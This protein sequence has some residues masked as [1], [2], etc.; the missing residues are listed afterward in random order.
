MA[1]PQAPRN[2]SFLVTRRRFFEATRTPDPAQVNLL[3]RFSTVLDISEAPTLDPFP[4]LARYDIGGTRRMDQD[5]WI[6][7]AKLF[8]FVID[9]PWNGWQ[10]GKERTHA[11]VAQEIHARSTVNTELFSYILVE[12]VHKSLA[13]PGEANHA[14]YLTLNT[15]KLWA[16]Q[17]GLTEAGQVDY[18]A[19]YFQNNHATT[20]KLVGGKRS[21]QIVAD[22]YLSWLVEGATV[23]N[24]VTPLANAANP[25]LDGIFID[26]VFP[27]FK[28]GVGNISADMDRNGVADN[29]SSTASRQLAQNSQVAL[30]DYIRTRLP[31]KKLLGNI[32]EWYLAPDISILSG[33]LNGGVIEGGIGQSYS[34]ETF[35]S[36]QSFINMINTTMAALAEPKW[37]VVV[38]ILD[39]LTNYSL[40][41]Y[42]LAA[43]SMT[44]AY[45]HTSLSGLQTENLTIY[46][47]YLVSLGQPVAGPDGAVQTAPRY[48]VGTNGQPVLIWRR[49]F[50]HGIVLAAARRGT[51]AL[52]SSDQT[53]SYASIS[54][55]GTFYR[56]SG[57]QDAV[58]N[59]GA[60]VQNIAMVPRTGLVLLRTT[61]DDI[62]P[63]QP[64]IPVLTVVS[65]TRI[66]ISWTA[67]TDSGGSGLG[68]Y[69]L[70][71]APESSPGS[72]LP[73][74]WAQISVQPGT[75][76]S[77]ATLSASTKY[78]YRVVAFDNATPPNVGI[79]S[80]VANA[81]TQ[82]SGGA[83]L[84]D[85]NFSSGA[86]DLVQNGVR[87]EGAGQNATI[88]ADATNVGSGFALQMR[89]PV[90]NPTNE[91]A[92]T[93]Q[94][95]FLGPLAASGIYTDVTIYYK[96]RVP[97]NYTHPNGPLFADPT[98]RTSDNNK[99]LRAWKGNTTDGVNG[100]QDYYYKWGFSTVPLVTWGNGSRLISEFGTDA[101]VGTSGQGVGQWGTPAASPWINPEDRGQ[102]VEFAMRL[103]TDT[104]GQ[105]GTVNQATGGNG[106]LQAWR[107]VAGGSW[108]Q[109][110]NLT[111]IRCRSSNGQNEFWEYLYFLGYLNQAWSEE[112]IWRFHRIAIASGPNGPAAFGI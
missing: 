26:N 36:F 44:N 101:T 75:T 90:W 100:Y 109:I 112:M 71:R 25:Y 51:G 35:D 50:E 4:H 69:G 56:F 77:D 72:G 5:T 32:A 66:D 19:N 106:V 10:L 105:I 80:S 79:Y 73:G 92:H 67:S 2:M 37:G 110:I 9:A 65:S 83:I 40:M 43:T 53:T 108:V 21:Y 86:K 102:L 93:E 22:F 111:T 107:R 70:D 87:Y 3:G 97:S 29:F 58:T 33:K 34:P 42:Q 30:M 91:E 82:A 68:G 52:A 16:Y 54:L 99:W 41:R 28:A 48:T 64:G 38:N 46:D 14:L 39:S 98:G 13:T 94:R 89:V 12:T 95:M 55:G 104:I 49:D 17:N 81:T 96:G 57:T 84:W 7:K 88:V 15:N 23:S 24:G 74:T 18:D 63:T 11:E 45:F 27:Y 31:G 59:S 8:R 76:Y 60:A 103:K 47:E 62:A 6:D 1:T 61:Q 20:G 85:H 78:F